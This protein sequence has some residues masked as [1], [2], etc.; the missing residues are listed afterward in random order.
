[1]REAREQKRQRQ[2]ILRVVWISAAIFIAAGVVALLVLRGGGTAL[3]EAVPIEPRVDH[4]EPGTEYEYSTNPP[5]S[6]P[7]YDEPAEAGFYSE[8]VDDGYLVHSLE[9]GYVVVWYNCDSLDAAACDTLASNVQRE[10][11]GRAKVIGMPRSGME[12]TLALTSWGRLLRLD[13]FDSATI[14]AF[15]RANLN[16]APEPNAD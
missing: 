15:I 9:H 6:G 14:R 7:H 5:T 8:P 1:V 10:V 4:F 12:T 13:E 11:Q 16:Q 2:R 3:G